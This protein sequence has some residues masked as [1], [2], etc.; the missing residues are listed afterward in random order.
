MSERGPGLVLAGASTTNVEHGYDAAAAAMLLNLI[1]GHVG[2]T[3]VA[4]S[5]FP[6]PALRARQGN[7]KDLLFLAKA[8]RDKKLDVLVT[9]NVNPVFTAPDVL[10]LPKGLSQVGFKVAL[11]MFPDETA[12]QADLVLPLASGMEDWG[13]HVAAYQAD[14]P[15]LGFQQPLMEPIHK[16]TRGFGDIMLTMLKMRSKDYEKF[17]NYYSYLQAAVV[18]MPGGSGSA[19]ERWTA[20]LQSG[21]VKTKGKKGTLSPR[22]VAMRYKVERP[23]SEYPMHLIPSARLGM[24]DGRHANIPWIQEAPDQIA[25]VVWDSWAEL[26]PKKAEE[27]G[28]KNGDYIRITS[29]SGTIEAQVYVHHGIHPE[30]VAVPIGQGHSE[31]GRYAKNRGVNPLKILNPLMEKRTGELASHATRVNVAAIHKFEPLVKLG[32]SESQAGRRFVRT[33]SA[34]QLER[35]EGEA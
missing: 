9:Y 10:Q 19:E 32:A 12:L 25:K 34:D 22:L 20:T 18:N 33:I 28:V 15:V 24:W 17:D 16:E 21:L 23:N 5:K 11:T 26:H 3:I 4:S 31:Y 1:M 6:E 35:T 30:A 7:T 2:E 14:E 27:L 29:A 13:T 8:L